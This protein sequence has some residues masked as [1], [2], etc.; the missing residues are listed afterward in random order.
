VA[1]I[2]KSRQLPKRDDFVAKTN[3]TWQQSMMN[4]RS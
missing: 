4:M 1:K 2:N 3:E